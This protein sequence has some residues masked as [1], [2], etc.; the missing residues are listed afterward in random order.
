[1]SAQ[2]NSPLIPAGISVS[3]N[4]FL[5]N[6]D[7]DTNLQTCTNSLL[8]ITK[9]FAPGGSPTS[10]DL[11]S[12]LQG[13]CHSN[14]ACSDSMLRNLL[15]EFNKYCRDELV[16]SSDPDLK[17]IY[18]I[19]YMFSPFQ[20]TICSTDPS[21]NQY[22]VTNIKSHLTH[23]STSG[24]FEPRSSNPLT[25][26][27]TGR[28]GGGATTTNTTTWRALNIPFQC[29]DTSVP[30]SQLCT[31]CTKSILQAYSSFEMLIPYA[32]G[33][34]NSPLLGEQL[35]IW[36]TVKDKCGDQYMNTL[37]KNLPA[38]SLAMKGGA[39]SVKVGMTSLSVV[40]AFVSGLFL[41][42]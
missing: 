38:G 1:N 2:A 21:T 15:T 23:R 34:A 14:D 33:L 27:L 22:C 9:A 4:N 42:A 18:D 17:N 30:A 36:N 11:T 20:S 6:L 13:L 32:N 8:S 3:C 41:V 26:S 39:V 19:L 37:F 35:S 16:S 40:G 5:D 25:G 24:D 28:D 7:T 29:L 12:T 10:T 31:A